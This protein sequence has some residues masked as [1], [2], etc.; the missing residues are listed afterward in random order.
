MEGKKLIFNDLLAFMWCK[1]EVTPRDTLINAITSYYKSEAILAARDEMA[2]NSES[3]DCPRLKQRKTEQM[4]IAIY[5]VMM[6]L[7]VDSLVV[8]VAIDLNNIPCIDMK[9]ID[10]VAIQCRQDKL[11]ELVENLLSEQRLMREQIVELQEAVKTNAGTPPMVS[12]RPD[13]QP[14]DA[15]DD[16]QQAVRELPPLRSSDGVESARREPRTYASIATASLPPQQPRRSEGPT[17]SNQRLQMGRRKPPPKT[18][19]KEGNRLVVVP[20]IRKTRVF[21]SRLGPECTVEA[22]KSYATDLIGCECEVEKLET[23][24]PTYSS[25]VI[26]CNAQFRDKLLKPIF[27]VL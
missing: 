6:R 10:G 24:F 20:Q 13:P 25:F 19:R 21:V 2:Q 26:S 22:I 17:P 1:M 23:K 4:L 3:L 18:G 16:G 27:N 14:L 9:N 11:M 7:K 12:E 8:F 5:E 15:H